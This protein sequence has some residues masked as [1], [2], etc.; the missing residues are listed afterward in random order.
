[1]VWFCPLHIC[2]RKDSASFQLFAHTQ[3]IVLPHT[4]ICFMFTLS[5]ML[6]Y[7]FELNNLENVTTANVNE[8]NPADR[9]S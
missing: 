1:V 4:E 8:L 2:G 6:S 3:V 9:L 5:A 7:R